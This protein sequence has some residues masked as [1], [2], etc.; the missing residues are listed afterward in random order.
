MAKM[1]MEAWEGSAK[2]KAQDI[3]LAKK[4]NMSFAKWEA[5]SMDD[6]H[7]KQQSMKGLKSGGSASSRADGCCSRGMTRG[8]MV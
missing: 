3:K 4:H 7:D 2:D 6:K 8:K 5:S 1:S